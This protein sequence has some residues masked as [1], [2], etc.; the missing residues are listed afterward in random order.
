MG[1][2]SRG[3]AEGAALSDGLMRSDLGDWTKRCMPGVRD[4]ASMGGECN[5]A[6]ARVMGFEASAR[7]SVKDERESQRIGADQSLHHKAERR[8]GYFFAWSST[9]E[10]KAVAK[11]VRSFLGAFEGVAGGVEGF[12]EGGEVDF[13]LLHGGH[14]EEDEGLAEVVVEP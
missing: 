14:V 3:C 5:L 6:E 12:V 1:S 2:I 13:R 7:A 4:D 8:T 9:H 11:V 10:A